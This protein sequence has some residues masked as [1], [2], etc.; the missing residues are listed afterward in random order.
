[1]A[2]G[3]RNISIDE[4]IEQKKKEVLQAK[5][6]Y[7]IVLAELNALQKKKNE[8]RNKELLKAVEKSNRSMEEILAFL[9]GNDEES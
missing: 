3:R 9:L 4:K 2:R 5:E 8:L 1:M 7:D 6:K